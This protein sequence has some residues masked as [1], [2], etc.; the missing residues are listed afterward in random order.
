MKKK[1]KV[2]KLIFKLYITV[3]LVFV[4]IGILHMQTKIS[5]VNQ[6]LNDSKAEL[7]QLES[8]NMDLDMQISEELTRDK[9][10]QFA[11][12]HGLVQS[13]ASVLNVESDVNQ[14]E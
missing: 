2:I 7:K 8:V 10:S 4:I 3:G 6:E 1:G 13:A 11:D 12:A 5:V 9:I 14:N